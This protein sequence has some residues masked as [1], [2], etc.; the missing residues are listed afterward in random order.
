[1]IGSLPELF[2]EELKK[3][4]E[5]YRS[6]KE[7]ASNNTRSL[8]SSSSIDHAFQ[9][10]KSEGLGIVAVVEKEKVVGVVDRTTI[11]RFIFEN[12]KRGIL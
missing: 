2:V 7:I 9:V 11:S 8:D 5:K 12:S 6:I 4:P 10:M 3:K 1:M